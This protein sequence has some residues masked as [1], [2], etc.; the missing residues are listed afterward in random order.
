M[1]NYG[2]GKYKINCATTLYLSRY[3]F[4]SDGVGIL[5]TVDILASLGVS[6]EDRPTPIGRAVLVSLP[7][8]SIQRKM[9]ALPFTQ[10]K[11]SSVPSSSVQRVMSCVPSSSTKT[12]PALNPDIRTPSKNCEMTTITAE[13]DTIIND[14][15]K[16]MSV[17]YNELLAEFKKADP[18]QS[19]L[20]CGI[21]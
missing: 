19:G 16:V 4:D 2:R 7:S 17:K 5:N 14:I 10:R 3:R 11:V 6:I 9:S 13:E 1:I 21:V 8:S 18:L 12:L 15:S 20:V